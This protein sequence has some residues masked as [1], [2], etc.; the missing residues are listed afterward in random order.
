MILIS[1]GF[2]NNRLHYIVANILGLNET[3]TQTQLFVLLE[4]PPFILSN[5]V[6][7]NI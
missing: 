2:R 6:E 7:P 3:M 4:F 5:V 1:L